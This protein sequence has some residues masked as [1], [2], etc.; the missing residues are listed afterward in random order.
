MRDDPV[1][2]WVTWRADVSSRPARASAAL[3]TGAFAVSVAIAVMIAAG[4][5]SA[6]VVTVATTVCAV[7]AVLARHTLSALAAGV[8]LRVAR[9]Y[10]PGER[11]CLYVPSLG[12]IVEAEIVRVGPA[13][14][15]LASQGGLILVPNNRMLRTGPN[16]SARTRR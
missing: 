4:L 16:P 10:C 12:E 8:G 6:I 9:P 13:N 14:T 5:P 1:R 11:V 7:A 2:A 15:T 3:G